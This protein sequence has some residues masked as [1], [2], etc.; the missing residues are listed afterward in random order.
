M[1]IRAYLRKHELTQE[2]FANRLGVS[3]GLVWQWINNRTRV[4]AE[5]AKEIEKET[6]GE[7]PRHELRRD[8]FDKQAAA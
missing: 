5:W 7:V 4:T 1:N 6:S 2:E 3:P 8:I